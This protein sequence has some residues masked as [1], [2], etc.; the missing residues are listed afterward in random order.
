M[1]LTPRNGKGTKNGFTEHGGGYRK[2]QAEDNCLKHKA[3]IYQYIH[4]FHFILGVFL[5]SFNVSQLHQ[6]NK[7]F[8][9]LLQGIE[10]LCH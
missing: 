2:V 5:N 10:S 1:N 8:F 7:S 6:P 4:I 3:N 9:I